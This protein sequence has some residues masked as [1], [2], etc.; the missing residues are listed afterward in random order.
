[1]MPRPPELPDSA[2]GE[3]EREWVVLEGR[4]FRIDRPKSSDL[5]LDYPGVADAFQADEYLPYWADLWPCARMLA[6]AILRRSWPTGLLALELGCGLGLGGIA[7]L[8]QG[9]HVVFSDYDPNALRFAAANARLNGFK[10]FQTLLLDWRDPPPSRS[11]PLILAS[12]VCYEQRHIDPLLNVLHALLAAEGEC[13]LT[14]QDRP[15][16]PL[17]RERL[18]E[19]GFQYQCEPMRVGV[20]GGDRFK[21]TLYRIRRKDGK[22][23]EPRGR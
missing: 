13:W 6:K 12:D 19:K 5:L 8:A 11:F 22:P 21:G 10:N 4:K 15:P 16:A 2:W 18:G 1:M 23:S 14:D 20:P 7:A 3:V 17:F 9:L